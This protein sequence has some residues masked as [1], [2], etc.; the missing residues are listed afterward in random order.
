MLINYISS[1]G[2]KIEYETYQPTGVNSED[3]NQ[4][5]V[6]YAEF[7]P[8]RLPTHVF[9]NLEI[10]SDFSRS[11]FKGY[12]TIPDTIDGQIC[13]TLSTAVGI[14]I[15]KPMPMMYKDFNVIVGTEREFELFLVDKVFEEV[16]LADC[17]R[18]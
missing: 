17:E 6:R 14:L 7:H 4:V 2:I 5:A 13:I 18:E 12:S 9:M 16:V 8:D 3:L 1:E 10:Y 15:V 11:M